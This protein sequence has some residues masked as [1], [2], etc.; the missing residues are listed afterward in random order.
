MTHSGEV[1]SGYCSLF[2]TQI[3]KIDTL[4][5]YIQILRLS[6]VIVTSPMEVSLS[7]ILKL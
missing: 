2:R 4:Y 5:K 3:S 1:H 7:K 6:G